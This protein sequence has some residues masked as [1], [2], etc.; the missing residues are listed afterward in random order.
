M[1]LLKARTLCCPS[2]IHASRN[3]SSF[4]GIVRVPAVEYLQIIGGVVLGAS[5]G[6]VYFEPDISKAATMDFKK[7]NMGVGKVGME[8]DH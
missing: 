8:F 3:P 5:A 4:I 6:I 2:T 7:V 1:H